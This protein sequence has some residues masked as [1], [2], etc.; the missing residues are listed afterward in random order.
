LYLAVQL[1]KVKNNYMLSLI[2]PNKA[3]F[4]V[5]EDGTELYV[6]DWGCFELVPKTFEPKF[7]LLKYVNTLCGGTTS[8]PIVLPENLTSDKDK[9]SLLEQV[10]TRLQSM[11]FKDIDTVR[12]NAPEMSPIHLTPT[13]T[14]TTSIQHQRRPYDL[15]LT[16]EQKLH[17]NAGKA[18]LPSVENNT[19]F[20]NKIYGLCKK[21]ACRTAVVAWWSGLTSPQL[22]TG[23]DFKQKVPTIAACS[24]CSNAKNL[25]PKI[26]QSM[27]QKM[28]LSVKEAKSKKMEVELY[29]ITKKI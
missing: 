21:E 6:I 4:I 2:D 22:V 10:A 14:I 7:D 9:H 5:S 26:L 28:A 18:L 20:D 12:D 8:L 3:N 23:S 11:C 29:E 16:E 19:K 27:S 24:K 13:T 25:G 17:I 1:W 15:P